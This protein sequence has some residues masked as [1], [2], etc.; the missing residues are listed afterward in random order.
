MYDFFYIQ[1]IFFIIFCFPLFSTVV[2]VQL[3]P[4]SPHR[5]P[6][7]HTSPPPTLYPTPVGFVCVSFIMYLDDHPPLSPPTS[8][9]VTVSLLF[10]CLW[11][12]LFACLFSYPPR[13]HAWIDLENIMLSE[14][15][16]AEKHKYHMIL[17][18]C[19]I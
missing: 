7:P 5:S 18:I 2:Q 19:G 14:I 15:S 13:E 10:Q 4:F 11:Y 16:Q 1:N 17:L 3:S 9:L 6:S 8:H 12:I